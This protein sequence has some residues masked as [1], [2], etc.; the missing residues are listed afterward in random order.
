[1]PEPPAEPAAEPLPEA[2]PEAL[3]EPADEPAGTIARLNPIR[4]ASATRR[5]TPA[6]LRTSP[7][8]PTSPTT[9]TPCGMDRSATELASATAT[10]RS[11]DGSVSRTPPTV[12]A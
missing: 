7:A 10:A 2:L 8:R 3:P 4:S 1:M 6:T 9:I 11:T 5:G 12:A